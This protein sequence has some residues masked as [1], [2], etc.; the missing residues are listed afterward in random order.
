M[1][2][3]DLLLL[4]QHLGLTPIPL[5]PRCKWP[6]V[7]WGNGWNR[8]REDLGWWFVN[9]KVNVGVLCGEDLAA[10]D[11]DSEET[12]RDF[13]ATHDLPPDCPI[14]KAARGYHIWVKPS[15]PIRSQ[16]SDGTKAKC[17]GSYIAV[18]SS[19]H[20]SGASYIFEAAPKGILPELDIEEVLGTVLL[21]L[22][23]K[24]PNNKGPPPDRHQQQAAEIVKCKRH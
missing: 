17:V 24:G 14:V 23:A 5:K 21:P 8:T 1:N 6:F 20:L 3:P 13:T 15:R 4:Y 22:P 11:C 19:I 10:I 7:R 18:P 12:F 16:L 9:N 2:R